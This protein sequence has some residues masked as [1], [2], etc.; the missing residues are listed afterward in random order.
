MNPTANTAR[1]EFMNFFTAG[2]LF[3]GEF[4][5]YY[6]SRDLSGQSI[7]NS[8]Y[9]VN[10]A[11]QKRI[12]KDKGTL[13]FGVDDMLHSWKYRNRSVDVKQSLFYQLSQSDTQR[14]NVSL[15]YRFGKDNSRK[16]KL[17]RNVNDE[18]KGRLE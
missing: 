10:V 7:T 3:N 12:L 6:A 4:G 1:F 5:G 16:S 14:F 2:K 15:T 18:E 8:M 17:N 9:R 11:I 13:R